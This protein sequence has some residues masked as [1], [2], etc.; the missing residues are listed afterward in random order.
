MSV[1]EEWVLRD[2]DPEPAPGQ[3]DEVRAFSWW[4]SNRFP[5]SDE[6][7]DMA[8]AWGEFLRDPAERM[9][10][11]WH[12]PAYSRM[13]RT[14][15][16]PTRTLAEARHRVAEYLS[17]GEWAGVNVLHPTADPTGRGQMSSVRTPPAP[18]RRPLP[19][20][21]IVRR[22]VWLLIVTVASGCLYS[23][24]L[25]AGYS[26]AVLPHQNVGPAGTT[27]SGPMQVTAV[28][29]ASPAMN[30]LL[31]IIVVAALIVVLRVAHDE[32]SAVTILN[33]TMITIV[34]VAVGALV[35]GYVWFYMTPLDHWAAV[36]PHF[37]GFPFVSVDVATELLAIR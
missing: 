36:G 18:E 33:L 14:D 21:R 27:Q 34:A 19:G 16:L 35:A 31:G 6:I 17:A 29:H 32:Q 15:P 22:V 8:R 9:Y 7:P 10:S 5:S 11:V 2:C 13:P 12:L 4:L 3:L 23:N 20:A 25:T 24:L 26:G 37:T 1:A 30:A 28:M